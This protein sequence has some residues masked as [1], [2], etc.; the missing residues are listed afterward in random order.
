MLIN[1]VLGFVELI[2]FTALE[3]GLYRKVKT[4]TGTGKSQKVFLL[5]GNRKS[6]QSRWEILVNGNS[7]SCPFFLLHNL[8]YHLHSE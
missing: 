8:S 2:T 7:C 5:F 6:M 1:S 3:H 4:C